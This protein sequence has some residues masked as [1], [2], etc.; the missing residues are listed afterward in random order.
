MYAVL[1]AFLLNQMMAN[2]IETAMR[3]A[4]TVLVMTKFTQRLTIS[5]SDDPTKKS[6]G[7]SPDGLVY[8]RQNDCGC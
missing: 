1:I 2:K 5:G 3:E 6:W 7:I 4:E 8:A